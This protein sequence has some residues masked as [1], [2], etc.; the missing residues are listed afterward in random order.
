VDD[1]G[2]GYG[3]TGGNIAYN[4]DI[5]GQKFYLLAK[6][7]YD[8]G[9]YLE[10][11]Q[12]REINLEMII[13]E[14]T[15]KTAHA[16]ILS[17]SENNQIQ[18]FFP[19]PHVPGAFMQIPNL[20]DWAFIHIAPSTQSEMM[21]LVR[22]TIE[23]KKQFIFDPGQVT[24]N[25][26][27]DDLSYVMEHADLVI[28]NDYEVSLMLRTLECTFGEFAK[29]QKQLIVTKGKE[30]SAYFSGTTVHTVPALPGIKVKDPTG[31]GDAFRAGVLWAVLK[32]KSLLDG[33][34]LGSLMS[35]Y[36]IEQFGAQGH[37]PALF[38]IKQRFEKEYNNPIEL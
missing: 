34:R 8:G 24:P 38:E 12:N 26:S 23:Q 5:L 11:L 3:G 13:V 35:A 1:V 6:L 4:L 16:Y 17:D 27:K 15:L 37:Q 29:M 30:G 31:A 14:D 18:S 36:A 25:F 2:I 33:M 19:G 32:E 10:F 7:G 9:E 21:S 28:A 22:Q 20:A